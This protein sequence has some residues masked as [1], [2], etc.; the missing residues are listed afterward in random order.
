MEETSYLASTTSKWLAHVAQ[1]LSPI[2]PIRLVDGCCHTTPPQTTNTTSDR[3]GI[4]DLAKLLM[5]APEYPPAVAKRGNANGFRWRRGSNIA[6]QTRGPGSP[7][8]G[9]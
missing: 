6:L 5:K 9:Y 1:T 7:M 8:S 3:I 4:L 2:W